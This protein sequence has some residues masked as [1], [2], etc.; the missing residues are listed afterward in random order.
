MHECVEPPASCG[1]KTFPP[2]PLWRGGVCC[3]CKNRRKTY[4]T[5]T[6]TRDSTRKWTWRRVSRHTP[7]SPC[8]SEA[9]RTTSECRICVISE[10]KTSCMAYIFFFLDFKVSISLPCLKAPLLYGLYAN[11][12][13]KS[14]RFKPH[15]G[16]CC[17]DATEK[18]IEGFMFALPC[19][20]SSY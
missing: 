5:C 18:K 15:Q 11:P 13:V 17:V 3:R 10:R 8:L 12:V 4:Q 14:N 20:P 9:G 7:S 16:S 19:S 6:L 1:R 2:F